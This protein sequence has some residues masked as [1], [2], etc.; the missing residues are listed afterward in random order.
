MVTPAPYTIYE[1]IYKLPAGF[2]VQ[3]NL[4][5]DCENKIS[6]KNWYCPVKK[7]SF[8]EKKEFKKF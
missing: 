5:K 4:D 1:K 3:I 2:Y 7:I 6:F 8:Q